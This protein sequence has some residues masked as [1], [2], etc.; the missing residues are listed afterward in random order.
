[1][2][3]NESLFFFTKYEVEINDAEQCGQRQPEQNWKSKD[4]NHHIM[5]AY[6]GSLSKKFKSPSASVLLA[7][8]IIE[9]SRGEMFPVGQNTIENVS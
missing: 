7:K 5:K 4:Q 2:V 8:V 9:K 3:L 1:M 6:R